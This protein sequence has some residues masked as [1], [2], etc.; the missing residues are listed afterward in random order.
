VTTQD[1]IAWRRI[2]WPVGVVVAV[3][4]LV[5]NG[6]G[7]ER[8]ELYFMMLKPAWGYVDQPPLTPIVAHTLASLYDGGPWLLRIPAT[9][10]AA[11]CVVLTAL[12]ARELGGAAKAQTWAAWGMATTSAVTVFGH[13]FLTS[14]PDLVFWPAVSLCVIRALVREQPRWWLLAG[15]VAG[16]ASYN[17]LLIAVLVAGLGLGLVV[18]GPRRPLR[19][20]YLWAGA[21]LAVLVAAPNLIYQVVDGWPQLEMGRALSDHNA[22]DVRVSM[23]PLLVLLLGPPLAVFWAVGLGTLWRDPRTRCCVAAFVV[24]VAFT[25]ASGTQAYY[26]LFFLPVPFAAGIVAMEAH[27]ARVWGGLFALNG[28][29]SATLGLPLVAVGQVGSTPIPDINQAVQDSVGWPAYVDQIDAVYEDA[30]QGGSGR[31]VVIAS[32]YGEAGAVARLRPG[33]PVFS[34]QNALYDQARPAPT[35][36]TVVFVGGELRF[37]RTLF[38]CE[39]VARLDNGVGVDNEE[40]GEPVAVCTH[41]RQPWPVIWDRLRHL[42]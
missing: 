1:P 2:V 24:V 10:C 12:I 28:A 3:L 32:N 25:F 22:S 9:L 17:K 23:W 42:D 6:Y 26:P 13:S 37:A 5:S 18:L 15:L 40:Q 29:V 31:V 30:Q 33:V 20:A 4:S 14:S 36:T 11:G 21:G 8:D 41:P 34:A 19:S 38:T 27:L 7:F 16:L 39:V 35:T